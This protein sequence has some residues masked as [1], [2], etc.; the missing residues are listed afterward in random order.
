MIY[1]KKA[2]YVQHEARNQRIGVYSV[3]VISS[4]GTIAIDL[5]L[6]GNSRGG[7]VYTHLVR[8]EYATAVELKIT[9]PSRSRAARNEKL[10]KQ[11]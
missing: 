2:S 8:V 10:Q 3:S 4:K 6:L 1:T 7:A 5:P 11:A 9:P